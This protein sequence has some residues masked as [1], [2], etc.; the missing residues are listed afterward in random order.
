MNKW[1]HDDGEQKAFVRD[2]DLQTC[3][4]QNEKRNNSRPFNIPDIIVRMND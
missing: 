4:G 3:S 2:R 1:D